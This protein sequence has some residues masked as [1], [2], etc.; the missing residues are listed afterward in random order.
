MLLK[1]NVKNIM[2]FETNF[3]YKN[4]IIL[5]LFLKI[6]FFKNHF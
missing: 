5:K 2:N 1:K 3:C 6:L 4:K